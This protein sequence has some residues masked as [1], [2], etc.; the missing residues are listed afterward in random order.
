MS[1]FGM[2]ARK[3]S[4]DRS[5]FTDHPKTD[6]RKVNDSFFL[7]QSWISKPQAVDSESEQSQKPGRKKNVISKGNPFAKVEIQ[8][9]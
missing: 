4:T 2:R 6:N 5:K 1:I 8:F 3:T 7:N 9:V